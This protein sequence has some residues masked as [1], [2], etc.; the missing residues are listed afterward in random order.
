MEFIHPVR[1]Y[2]NMKLSN[3]MTLLNIN[4]LCK[5]DTKIIMLRKYVKRTRLKNFT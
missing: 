1:E 3:R 4:F 2:K 5:H